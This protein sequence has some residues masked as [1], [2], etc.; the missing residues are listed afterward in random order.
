MRHQKTTEKSLRKVSVK[1]SVKALR[2]ASSTS[3]AK[4]KSACAA[5]AIKKRETAAV[6]ADLDYLTQYK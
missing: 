4:S 1:M 3:W 5:N 2:K 6:I